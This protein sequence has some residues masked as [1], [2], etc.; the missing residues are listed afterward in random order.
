L[1]LSENAK[2]VLEA[3]YLRRNGEGKVIESPDELL[4]RVA[5]A[6]SAAEL[7]YGDQSCAHV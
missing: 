2:K 6:V 5:G 3:R 7:Q 4:R 1:K